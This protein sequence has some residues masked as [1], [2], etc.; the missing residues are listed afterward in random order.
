MQQ[1]RAFPEL[2]DDLE[3]LLRD[4]HAGQ[5][6]PLPEKRRQLLAGRIALGLDPVEAGKYPVAK[7]SESLAEASVSA[8]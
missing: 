6:H 3:R 8:S 2:M 7:N 5:F 4:L 1:S